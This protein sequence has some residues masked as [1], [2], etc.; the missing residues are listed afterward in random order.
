MPWFLIIKITLLFL[1]ALRFHFTIQANRKYHQIRR[2]RPIIIKA[3]YWANFFPELMSQLTMVLTSLSFFDISVPGI[4]TN[5]QYALR[6]SGLFLFLTG[7]AI[8]YRA[9]KSLGSNY[10]PDLH[11]RKGQTLIQSG[12][13]RLI[14]HPYYL[15]TIFCHIGMAL[16]LISILGMSMTLA[17][18]IPALSYRIR[19]EEKLLN[20]YFQAEYQIYQERTGKLLP[21]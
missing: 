8:E 3:G 2:Q 19:I 21:G 17:I 14:R 10:S 20:K 4:A 15:G 7:W 12:I 1:I 13:Y 6:L 16:T 9:I 18:L 11:I 5:W